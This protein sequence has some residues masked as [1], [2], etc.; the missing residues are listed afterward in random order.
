MSHFRIVYDSH[1]LRSLLKIENSSIAYYCFSLSQIE[2]ELKSRKAI[3]SS[4]ESRVDSLLHSY[5]FRSYLWYVNCMFLRSNLGN[6]HLILLSS[7]RG[8]VI[9]LQKFENCIKLAFSNIFF[10]KG[11]GLWPIS[12]NIFKKKEIYRVELWVLL[13]KVMT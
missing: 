2:L 1:T 3:T 7:C 6:T 5:R 9:L 8:S 12:S 13:K 11:R 10:W 4:W